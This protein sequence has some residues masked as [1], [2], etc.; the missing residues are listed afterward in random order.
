MQ[1]GP[2]F[3]EDSEILLQGASG[4]YK[5]TTK[6]HKDGRQEV[7]DG[8]L[9]LPPDVYNGMVFTVVKNLSKGTTATIHL[10]VFTPKP[11]LI[12]LELAPAGEQTMMVSRWPRPTTSSSPIRAAGSNSSRRSSAACHRTTMSGCSLTGHPRSRGSKDR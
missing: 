4:K 5:V 9:T 2:T 8:T 3:A 7:I 10:V 11:L 12:E 6:S 1:R